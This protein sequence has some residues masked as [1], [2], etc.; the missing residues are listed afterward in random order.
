M[1]GDVPVVEM[2]TATEGAFA[3]Q[4]DNLPYVSP[5]YDAYLF[6]VETSLGV[7]ML[8]EMKRGDW[9][10]IIISTAILPRY[11]QG[12]LVEAMG[13]NYFRV[14]GRDKQSVALEHMLWRLLVGW[15]V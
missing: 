6:E 9:G 7:K 2:Y 10:R 12:D 13:N 1:Y 11:R 4:K 5:N 14:F 15:A 8:Y 3:Q